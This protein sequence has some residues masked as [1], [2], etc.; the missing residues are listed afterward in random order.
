MKSKG[1]VDVG[2]IVDG[3]RRRV[4][5]SEAVLSIVAEEFTRN[6][7]NDKLDQIS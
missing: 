3:K 6:L 4:M 1:K 5:S 7:L 2:N